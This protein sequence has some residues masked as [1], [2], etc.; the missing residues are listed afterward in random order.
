MTSAFKTAAKRLLFGTAGVP[1]STPVSTTLAGIAHVQRMGL[2][3]LEVEFVK[4]VK[5]GSD[6][7]GEIRKK[8]EALNIRLS[9][10]APYYINLN[11]PEPGKR[12]ASQERLTAT[13]RA[14]ALCGAHDVVFHGG[15]YGH[16]SLED[17]YEAVKAGVREILSLLRAEKNPVTLRIETM[18]RRAQFGSLDEVL[19][20][21]REVEG[22]Q[23]CLD[24]SHIHAREG[25][26]NSY[27]DFQ[28]ILKKVAKKLGEEALKGLHIHIS[29]VLY[30]GRGEIKHL[31]L[32]DSDF[33]YDSWV[34][35]LKDCGAAGMVICESPNLETDALMLKNLYG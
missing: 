31:D 28:R 12:L 16:S 30:G 13:C 19:F 9:A 17:T 2:D 3:C 14:A 35:A 11:S 6:T 18:G 4:G 22:L 29:G 27:R 24:F 32:R 1:L 34:R 5:M 23:P 33:H 20:L 7:A 26:A 21:C 10:H 15:Y 25:G 8:A